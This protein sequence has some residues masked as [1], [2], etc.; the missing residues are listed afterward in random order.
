MRNFIQ[1]RTV[2]YW[3]NGK[4]GE[5]V[6]ENKELLDRIQTLKRECA[7]KNDHVGIMQRKIDEIEKISGSRG[8]GL[9]TTVVIIVVISLSWMIAVTDR[10][11]CMEERGYLWHKGQYVKVVTK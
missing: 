9:F 3:T 5:E 11:N 4:G 1:L 6:S 8:M 7:A 2:Q 10:D